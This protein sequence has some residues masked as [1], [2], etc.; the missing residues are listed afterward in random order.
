MKK[1]K[2]KTFDLTPKLFFFYLK[3]Y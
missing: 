1:E 2:E 3:K